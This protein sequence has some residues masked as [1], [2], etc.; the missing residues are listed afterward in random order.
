MGCAQVQ[1]NGIF[2]PKFG[3]SRN[4]FY[5]LLLYNNDGDPTCRSQTSTFVNTL[6]QEMFLRN[7]RAFSSFYFSR[8]VLIQ[9]I[10]KTFRSEA[11]TSDVMVPNVLVLSFVF[12]RYIRMYQCT[13]WSIVN[14]NPW[15]GLLVTLMS[16]PHFT[17][18]AHVIYIRAQCAPV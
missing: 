13:S 2:D 16:C 11:W 8:S 15:V 3:V 18:S 17:L 9:S 12:V 1:C 10:A 7:L 6:P 5:M 4:L 14:L